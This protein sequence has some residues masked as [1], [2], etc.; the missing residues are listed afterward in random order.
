[1]VSEV[2]WLMTHCRYRRCQNQTG[3]SGHYYRN[4]FT[5]PRLLAARNTAASASQREIQTS[6]F[7]GVSVE[8]VGL[9]FYEESLNK[10]PQRTADLDNDSRCVQ[11]KYMSQQTL[12]PFFTADC[13]TED[14]LGSDKS[15]RNGLTDCMYI[16][17]GLRS[18]EFV[19]KEAL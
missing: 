5:A 1:A 16:Y 4:Q 11:A 10:A 3:L 7:N 8:D 17:V 12:A 13:D 15:A 14:H 18:K 6:V 9:S 2:I 19:V